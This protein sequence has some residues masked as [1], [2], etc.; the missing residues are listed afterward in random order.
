M[1]APGSTGELLGK[2]MALRQVE[3]TGTFG[4]EVKFV[5][6]EG[7]AGGESGSLGLS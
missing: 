1:K 4:G 3:V 2:L 5:D 7:N 6:I